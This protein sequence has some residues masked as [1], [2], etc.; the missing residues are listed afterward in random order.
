MH[1]WCFCV[2]D[3]QEFPD[4]SQDVCTLNGHSAYWG[5]QFEY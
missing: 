4:V 5:K 2:V 1:N 3:G